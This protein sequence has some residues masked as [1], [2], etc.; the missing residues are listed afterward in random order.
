MVFILNVDTSLLQNFVGLSVSDGYI[1]TGSETN[2]VSHALH[3]NLHDLILISAVV[4]YDCPW[5]FFL[6]LCIALKVSLLCMLLNAS[7]MSSHN[8]LFWSWK[9]RFTFTLFLKSQFEFTSVAGTSPFT[10]LC[11]DYERSNYCGGVTVVCYIPCLFCH[12]PPVPHKIF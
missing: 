12:I 8:Y 6:K 2:E 1:A 4:M 7:R 5:F 3:S 9:G 10:A 11:D